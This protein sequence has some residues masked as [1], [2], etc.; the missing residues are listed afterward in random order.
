MPNH[1]ADVCYRCGKLCLPGEGVF[2]KVGRPQ[3]RK[4]PGHQLP[5]WLTQH[6]DCAAR[7][8]GTSVHYK[9]NPYPTEDNM[10]LI[11]KEIE[12]QLLKNGANPGQDH[13]PVL[14]LFCPWGAATWLITEMDPEEPDILFG[15]CDLGQ[16][17]PELGNVSLAELEGVSGPVGL[18]IERDMY[19]TAGKTLAEYAE[20][21]REARRIVA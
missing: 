10:K 16:G 7:F 18:K 17:F 12:R 9:F 21:A 3:R 8:R 4:W 13:K 19:F 2:E 11:T 6:H 20:E 5:N 15:L 1:F 14:K